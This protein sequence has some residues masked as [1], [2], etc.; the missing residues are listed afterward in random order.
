MMQLAR[1][2]KILFVLRRVRA[3]FIS[4]TR[5]PL[6]ADRRQWRARPSPN[7]ADFII[8]YDPLRS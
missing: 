8:L 1:A 3:G 4:V 6:M 5:R 7:V 2:R